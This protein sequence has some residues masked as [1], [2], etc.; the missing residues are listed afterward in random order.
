MAPLPTR[1]LK[2]WTSQTLPKGPTE[3]GGIARSMVDAIDNSS[4]WIEGRDAFKEKRAPRFTG[5]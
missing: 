5:R 1:A 2:R 4:D 3:I